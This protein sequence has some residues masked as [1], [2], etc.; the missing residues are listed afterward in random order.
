[1]QE[2]TRRYRAYQIGDAGAGDR[3]GVAILAIVLATAASTARAEE[4][5]GGNEAVVAKIEVVGLD[6]GLEPAQCLDVAGVDEARV[7]DFQA[8]G[9]PIDQQ[10]AASLL[11]CLDLEDDDQALILLELAGTAERTLEI[12][13]AAVERVVAALDAEPL[14]DRRLRRQRRPHHRHDGFD[15]AVA[16]IADDDAIAFELRGREPA[17]QR[18]L[19][20]LG[21]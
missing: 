6:G 10:D 11:L 2:G 7:F 19:V 13:L 16:G 21:V 3:R 14:G 18:T 9:Q 1:M 17:Q 20:R 8:R 15:A 4:I 5:E 12:D